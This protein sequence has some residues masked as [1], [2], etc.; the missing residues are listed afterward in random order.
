MNIFRRSAVLIASASVGALVLAGCS[1]D[2]TGPAADSVVVTDQ[3][4]KA[5]GSGMT[6]VF[7]TVENTGGQDI[8]VVSASSPL[9]GAVEL[10]EVAD[11]KMRQKEGGFTIGADQSHTLAPGGD[12]IMLMDLT[13]AV[14]PGSNVEITL[15]LGDGTTTTFEAQARDFSGNNEEYGDADS[16]DG[17][18]GLDH[19]SMNHGS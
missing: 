18:D 13:G 8:Q 2:A 4:A 17:M 7:A 11:G 5:A 19:G 6:A 16:A 9:S 3:W 15:T 1:S 12:H 10:H 14:A